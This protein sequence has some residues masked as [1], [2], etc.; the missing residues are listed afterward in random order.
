[1]ARKKSSRDIPPEETVHFRPGELLGRL[2]GRFGDEHGLSR[3][4][5]ARRLTSL[6]AR[7]LTIDVHD[8]IVELSTYANC[9]FD[10]AAQTVLVEIAA[11]DAERAKAKKR[12]QNVREREEVVSLVLQRY[13]SAYYSTLSEEEEK[14]K[15]R[16]RV[17]RY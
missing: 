8:E 4:E 15:A 10:S 9:D 3:G 13:H 5:A 1:M 11:G 2:I 6:A 14:R 17:R 7:G 16:V 12:P